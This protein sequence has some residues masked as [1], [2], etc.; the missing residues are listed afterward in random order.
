MRDIN[1]YLTAFKQKKQRQKQRKSEQKKKA[2]KEKQSQKKRVDKLKKELFV[3]QLINT[4][5]KPFQKPPEPLKHIT[6]I[7]VGEFYEE[8]LYQTR[9]ELQEW[10]RKHYPCINWDNWDRIV[11]Q[12]KQTLQL[13]H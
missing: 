4:H 10:E 1:E 9:E 2:V 11:Q 8:N 12:T 6:I 7:N 5:V 13:L 3:Q